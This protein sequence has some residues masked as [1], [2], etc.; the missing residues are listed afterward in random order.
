MIGHFRVVS[1]ERID[2][3]M[4]RLLEDEG[5]IV[6]VAI[7]CVGVDEVLV[8]MLHVDSFRGLK[9]KMDGLKDKMRGAWIVGAKVCMLWNPHGYWLGEG[10]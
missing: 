6:K 1:F 9:D 8:C 4:C 10:Y 7:G 5:L 2:V 3:C